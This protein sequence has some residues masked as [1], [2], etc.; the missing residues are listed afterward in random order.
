MKLLPA[1][2]WAE[3]LRSEPEVGM[4]YQTGDV[5][6]ADGRM[7]TDVIIESGY[8]TKIRGRA[9]I[10]FEGSDVVKIELTGRRWKWDE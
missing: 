9:D 7:F 5:T 1:D 3:L 6:L 8:I 10:P 4:G 2:R